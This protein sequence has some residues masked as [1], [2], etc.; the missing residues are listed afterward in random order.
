MSLALGI[1]LLIGLQRERAGSTLGGIRT[2]PLIALLG[3]VCGLLAVQW[4]GIVLAAGL[5][6]V[7]S[8]GVMASL[9]RL[10]DEQDSEM[11]GQTSEA[12][13]LLT[14]A[15][16]ALLATGQYAAAVVGG[17]VTAVLLQFKKPMHQFAGR[18][19]ER[20]VRAVMHLVIVSLIVL[21]V[22]PDR[23]FGPFSVLNPHEIWLMVVLI[24]SL[25]L[26]GYVAGKLVG[27]RAGVV[28]GGILGGLVS[29]TA[30]TVAY[31]RRVRD[32][33][34]GGGSGEAVGVAAP[35]IMIASTVAALRVIVLIA[36]AAPSILPVAG[37]PLGLLLLLMG[38]VS[39][40]MLLLGGQSGGN[41]PEQENPAALKS[42]LVFALV[43]AIVIFG[44]AA[45][46]AQLGDQAIFA[47]ALV[48]G[49]VDVDAI[50]L[51][52]SRL[53][54][55]QRVDPTTAWRV[56]MVATLTNLAFKAGAT[57]VLGSRALFARI[58]LGFGVSIA[59]GLMI[60]WLW[61]VLAG[62]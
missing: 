36:V 29:S 1:G 32:V 18:M 28:L 39:V 27:E 45:A 7:A 25:S 23:T 56:V 53:A 13:A 15:L 47:V 55:A 40:A 51:S 31:S 37:P 19:T 8:L 41:M 48:S 4:G 30:T 26:A 60:L 11:G 62:Q 21:P 33:A 22:L 49:I 20:D 35:V 61:P 42:A 5:V 43:Y 57:M 54:A 34:G 44:T 52:T 17:A 10:D 59:G 2:Y 38:G 24:V 3:A 12:A 16:G 14:F 50:T 46:K 58:A 6:G 9:S